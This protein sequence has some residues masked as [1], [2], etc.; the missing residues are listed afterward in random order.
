MS[1]AT[2][3]CA[4]FV[5]KQGRKGHRENAGSGSPDNRMTGQSQRAP[6]KARD[7][8]L[9]GCVMCRRPRHSSSLFPCPENGDTA[10]LTHLLKDHVDEV[11]RILPGTKYDHNTE[12]PR[13][14]RLEFC[15]F[16][17]LIT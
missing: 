11:S 8:V 15:D 13:R 7:P 4:I 3:L 2:F 17:S 6:W 1:L 12:V 5:L 10:E 9:P 14:P 16:P